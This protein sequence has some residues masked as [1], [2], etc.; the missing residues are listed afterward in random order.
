M[1]LAICRFSSSALAN[2]WSSREMQANGGRSLVS[3]VV[4]GQLDQPGGVSFW[5]AGT[6]PNLM[7]SGSGI[8]LLS[9]L[10]LPGILGDPTKLASGTLNLIGLRNPISLLVPGR[11]LYGDVSYQT[12]SNH[13][14]WGDTVD[15]Q[16]IVWGDTGPT[17]GSHIVWGDHIVWGESMMFLSDAP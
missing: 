10:E 14:V 17:S 16:H 7:Y 5:D 1:S 13:I 15:Q 8:R 6:I 12:A 4:G 9:L 3:T 2:F 11:V